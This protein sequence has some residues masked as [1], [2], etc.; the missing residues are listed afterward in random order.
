MTDLKRFSREG[1]GPAPPPRD[2]DPLT[3][4][5]KDL[6]R[7]GL[8]QRP[9]PQ[10][11][12]G[13]SALWERQAR[14]YRMFEH[15]QA[16]VHRSPWSE[17]AMAPE[18]LRLHPVGTC[19]YT[20]ESNADPFVSLFVT[21]TVPNLQ[22]TS[23]PVAI[24][25]FRTFVGLGPLDVHVEMTVDSTHNVTSTVTGLGANGVE[26]VGLPVHPGDVISAGV[27]LGETP[28]ARATYVLANETTSQTV[29]FGFDSGFPAAFTINAGISRDT[30]GNPTQNP[31]A[32]FG[33]V[34]FDEIS[35]YT[36]A[37]GRRSLTEGQA[38]TMVD[39]DGTTL[40]RPVRLNDSAFRIERA[41]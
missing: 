19:G 13:L 37:G 14:R 39:L 34:Y 16:K 8:P 9:D 27:C 2:F 36:K 6:A 15:L 17:S 25:N 41:D 4:D 12:P 28:P 23:S 22:Y 38:V 24:N 3:A 32:H 20:L 18:A 26:A 7:Y 11:R 33:V 35:A 29:N 21:W 10:G 1:D 5:P 30:G 40:A 31:L